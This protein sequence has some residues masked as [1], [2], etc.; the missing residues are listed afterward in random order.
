[1]THTPYLPIQRGRSRCGRNV[2][3]RGR[4]GVIEIAHQPVG[5]ISRNRPGGAGVIVHIHG[6]TAGLHQRSHRVILVLSPRISEDIRHI[7][8][9]ELYG[10]E[11]H[12][13]RGIVPRI[14]VCALPLGRILPETH[15][16]RN[17]RCHASGGTA[18]A[19]LYRT[20]IVEGSILIPV[21]MHH[22]GNRRTLRALCRHTL[23][24]GRKGLTACPLNLVGIPLQ[25][26]LKL[27]GKRV[28]ARPSRVGIAQH[29]S[30]QIVAG[31]NHEAAVI[32]GED[33][34]CRLL[35]LCLDIYRLCCGGI[36][37]ALLSSAHTHQSLLRCQRSCKTTPR[38]GHKKKN[39]K[40]FHD[41]CV[42]MALVM[43][44]VTHFF[45]PLQIKTPF[46]KKC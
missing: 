45:P 13:Q 20:F 18:R 33:I 28:I 38:Y 43:L 22:K 39:V 23:P 25:P 9:V 2:L 19:I 27:H 41:K 37:C 15:N 4:G 16:L 3:T 10:A 46:H 36:A 17:C 29:G 5:S 24:R 26:L 44:K 12:R 8:P 40:V 35:G 31:G 6:I 7:L 14:R 34:I 1:M 21:S 30:C 11:V 32:A 42:F